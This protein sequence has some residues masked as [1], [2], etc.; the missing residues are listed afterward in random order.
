MYKCGVSIFLSIII[1]VF[2]CSIFSYEVN[3]KVDIIDTAAVINKANIAY[4][5]ILFFTPNNSQDNN[6]V[7][8]ITLQFD[9]NLSTLIDDTSKIPITIFP[10][11]DCSWFW[12]NDNTLAC[13][14][15]S[16]SLK[17]A[18]RYT[19][20]IKGGKKI[21]GTDIIIDRDYTH[22]FVY[23]PLKILNIN[24]F[25]WEKPNLP[26]LLL[27]FNQPVEKQSLIENTFFIKNNKSK[28]IIDKVKAILSVYELVAEGNKKNTVWKVRPQSPLEYDQEYKLIIEPKVTP[29]TGDT[30]LLPQKFIRDNVIKTYPKVPK[31]VSI[32]CMNQEFKRMYIK[33]GEKIDTNSRCDTQSG[34]EVNFNTPINLDLA[35]C[36][37]NISPTINK[38]LTTE[39]CKLITKDSDIDF[40]T[41]TA[42]RSSDNNN[43]NT[44]YS[45]KFFITDLKPNT[46]YTISAQSI[47][48]PT[49]IDKI[50][51]FFWQKDIQ[52]SQIK[53]IFDRNISANESVQFLT[54]HLSPE[55]DVKKYTILEKNIDTDMQ[56][57][58]INIEKLSLSYNKFY[59][60]GA[61]HNLLNEY[62]F[63]KKED[64]LLALPLKIRDILGGKSGLI[65]GYLHTF[66]KSGGEK[67]FSAQVTPFNI[68]AK[69][70][71][72]N[73]LIWIT[74]LGT[75]RP[76]SDANIELTCGSIK[77]DPL[78]KILAA[79]KTDQDGV[80]IFKQTKNLYCDNNSL[81]FC[82]DF[83][84]PQEKNKQF[85]VIAKKDKDIGIL[86]LS[87][88]FKFGVGQSSSHQFLAKNSESDVLFFV[89]TTQELYK[90]GDLVQYKIYAR[91]LDKNGITKY[92]S[93]MKYKMIVSDTEQKVIHTVDNIAFSEFGTYA[94]EFMLESNAK[95]GL[96]H[97]E[98]Q[99]FKDNEVVFS[100]NIG[101]IYVS[102]FIPS[103][104]K[105]NTTIQKES[106]S[107]GDTIEIKTE[108]KFYSGTPYIEKDGKLFVTLS[109]ADLSAIIRNPTLK[110]FHFN[111][112]KAND[113]EQYTKEKSEILSQV[114]IKTDQNGIAKNKIEILPNELYYGKI[115]A[116]SI[117]YD[118]RGRS[119]SSSASKPYFGVDRFV[120][121]R[122]KQWV[123]NINQAIEI[124][125]I[126]IDTTGNLLEGV[127]ITSILE[128]KVLKL[129]TKHNSHNI[130]DTQYTIEWHK[131]ADFHNKS[132]IEQIEKCV[133]VA[134]EAGE[135]RIVATIED[136]KGHAHN[137]I[138]DIFI[139]GNEEYTPT[140][141]KEES[142]IEI[143]QNKQQ[144]NV[145]EIAHYLVKGL[146]KNTTALITVE[147]NGVLDSFVQK[148]TP[149]KPTVDILIK[150]N[151]LPKFNL[152][153][154]T[155]S[156]RT[157]NTEIQDTIGAVSQRKLDDAARPIIKM[158]YAQSEIVNPEKHIKLIIT[159]DKITYRPREKCK[160]M[161]Q[162][163]KK[164]IQEL[165]VIIFDSSIYEILK[166]DYSSFNI[167]KIIQKNYNNV[168]ISNFNLINNLR[169]KEKIIKFSDTI[170]T[171]NSSNNGIYNKIQ[172]Q[173]QDTIESGIRNIDSKYAA[174]WAPQLLTDKTGKAQVE[175][176]IPD[177]LTEWKVIVIAN[178]QENEFGSNIEKLSVAR[179]LELRP[180]GPSHAYNGDKFLAG[181]S[182]LN[183]T[184][185]KHDLDFSMSITG[186]VE[187]EINYTKKFKDV[188]PKA[189]ILSLT[190]ISTIH[191]N[192]I[193]N[194]LEN[195]E[196]NINGKISTTDG[197]ES[198]AL[199][200][201]IKIYPLYDL[202]TT[203]KFGVIRNSSIIGDISIP[204]E[205]IPQISSITISASPTIVGDIT[206]IIRNT[207]DYPYSSWEQKI[208]KALIA[209]YYKK[210]LE[211]DYKDIL[212]WSEAEDLIK[213]T[214]AEM[215]NYQ[216]ADG[217]M[218][219]YKNSN[220]TDKYLSAYTMIALICIKALGY[221]VPETSI[222][223]LI[224]Y[225]HNIVLDT[226]DIYKNS[227]YLDDA[228]PIALYGLSTNNAL[229]RNELQFYIDH[230]QNANLAS[231]AYYL[232]AA[233]KIG[234]TESIKKIIKS[235]LS[236]SNQ[237]T[238]GIWFTDT[239]NV[240]AQYTLNS[241]LQTNCLILD[242][243]TRI[244]GSENLG[245][246]DSR[247]LVNNIPSRLMHSI[248]DELNSQKYG[249]Y[250]NT[251]ENAI[252]ISAI[253]NY[254]KTYEADVANVS[255]DINIS[256]EKY[257]MN[258]TKKISEVKVVTY[259]IRDKDIS[260]K[261][262][263]KL[264]PSNNATADSIS[265]VKS[266]EFDLIE[267]QLYYTIRL[268]YIRQNLAKKYNNSGFEIHKE[269]SLWK[270]GGWLLLNNANDEQ[271][272][273]LHLKKGDVVRVDIYLI[274]PA[275]RHFVVIDD[276][277]A[278]AFEILDTN[279][280]SIYHTYKEIIDSSPPKS[281]LLVQYKDNWQNCSMK[282]LSSNNCAVQDRGFS[283]VQITDSA[284]RFYSQKLNKGK[285]H[286][287]YLTEVVSEGS[288]V[289]S[290]IKAIEIYNKNVSGSGVYNNIEV[291][292]E[293]R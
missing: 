284:I 171:V 163:S 183:N 147:R 289:A 99:A 135:Y 286:L 174:Y 95:S 129:K 253:A 269:Y 83:Y 104:F 39:Y 184:D 65:S 84:N 238:T 247:L 262:K 164:D 226:K 254:V 49:F 93:A 263:I 20:K 279:L 170:N 94:N 218:H 241:E 149:D 151:Y 166:R 222:N 89:I 288:F 200:H 154:T 33:V 108:A 61:E 85:M 96:Y 169:G 58:M 140:I 112:I 82:C 18:T 77:Y 24:L 282:S 194:I 152:S 103:S 196:I 231:K 28:K 92:H 290:P 54:S 105:I 179:E 223:S 216:A 275:L 74:D 242:I 187:K 268:D 209:S 8:Q 177:N 134:K 62:N 207:I 131:I 217:G 255:M 258:F 86:P 204:K 285:Y 46:S 127:D 266:K 150:E 176:L 72:F 109:Q 12:A 122:K 156:Q 40:S 36:F 277:I 195:H 243:F 189:N 245:Y 261:V 68:V 57:N 29:I 208:S 180:I 138:I 190:N 235:I 115:S 79:S 48:S 228:I 3:A 102:D 31:I 73:S 175:F 47:Q 21:E 240:A 215:I 178:S 52:N 199:K 78:Q 232:N 125:E 121:L 203:T 13:N 167:D 161:I 259:K 225:L 276:S 213:N 158:G 130:D 123:Y 233:Y 157:D 128:K 10:K 32:S 25:E 14:T 53:D 160:I 148:L 88:S 246:K 66:P 37:L 22:T 210:I 181:F 227:Q 278:G 159:P 280:D 51:S 100:Q 193:Q 257:K 111:D 133:F 75:G 265:Q 283:S 119:H 214:L 136:L 173:S 63:N 38:K 44:K 142:I 113:G 165:A 272:V 239:S 76:V 45:T 220:I 291:K 182:I 59:Y 6:D 250:G 118:E 17:D 139:I 87:S 137:S 155:F 271:E 116:K 56:V 69:I 1:L 192:Q 124:E 30:T 71:H 212:M 197:K 251:H 19:L 153:I 260:D 292:K 186:G 252:C 4:T 237:T 15:I 249:G 27:T 230:I 264:R 114:Y 162:S 101:N 132:S 274:T 185:A 126:V 98:I 107:L 34:V 219:Y 168:S 50:R 293:N 188:L 91:N 60:N 90:A 234:D 244:G 229:D 110:D 144:Y 270:D 41:N 26:V 64:E 55:C 281:N 205:V 172:N 81:E 97:I 70:G 201:V 267:Q 202:E 43:K 9:K 143:I 211:K 256:S 117:I 236:H 146:H 224:K 198:D 11:L 5:K 106:Y 35:K 287:S 42:I 206:P 2:S 145:G 120:G 191:N 248:R 67:E 16:S 80:A 7:S 221:N 23:H 273:F 141:Q